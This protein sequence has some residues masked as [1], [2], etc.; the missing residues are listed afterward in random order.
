MQLV[1]K[2]VLKYLSLPN[3]HEPFMVNWTWGKIKVYLKD[4]VYQSYT[5]LDI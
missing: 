1:Y 2:L 3:I 4:M 5:F